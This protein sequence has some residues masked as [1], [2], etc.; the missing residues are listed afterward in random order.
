MKGSWAFSGSIGA[1]ALLLSLMA[2]ADSQL[3]TG[4]ATASAGASAHLNFRIIIPKTLSLRVQDAS[5]PGGHSE[6]VSVHSNG[7][8]VA[9]NATVRTHDDEGSEHGHLILSAAARKVIDQELPCGRGDAQL[10]AALAAAATRGPIDGD[11][12]AIVCTVS[13]P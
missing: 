12:A 13:M 3:Q 5:E 11:H 1:A 7:H 9:L 2:A 6:T 10:A 8:S 4:A